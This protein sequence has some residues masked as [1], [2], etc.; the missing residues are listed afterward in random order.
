MRQ[1]GPGA[2]FASRAREIGPI[3]VS[4]A[5]A[6]R[7]SAARFVVRGLALRAQGRAHQLL[8]G[9]IVAAGAMDAL[10]V[11][12]IQLSPWALR[13]GVILQ[14]MDQIQDR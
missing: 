8:A 5:H 9:A 11:N 12:Q 13:E 4:T 10:G 1:V 14:R 2:K 3:D 7:L 6:F